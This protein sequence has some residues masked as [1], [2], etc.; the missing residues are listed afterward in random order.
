MTVKAT[1]HINFKG[2]AAPRWSSTSPSS[3]AS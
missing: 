1:T 3:A 2:D